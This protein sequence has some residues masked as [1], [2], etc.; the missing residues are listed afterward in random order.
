MLTPLFE[1]KGAREDF[2]EINQNMEGLVVDLT[3]LKPFLSHVSSNEALKERI[4]FGK[5]IYAQGVM[6]VAETEEVASTILV[7]AYF[8]EKEDDAPTCTMAELE[9]F[10]AECYSLKPEDQSTFH[11]MVAE[12]IV[13]EKSSEG[14]NQTEAKSKGSQPKK[15]EQQKEKDK[16]K[17][18]KKQKVVK[19]D[20]EVKKNKK[21]KDKKGK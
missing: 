7:A 14:T 5:E 20:K 10:A 6:A 3:A 21:R 9:K 15:N 1:G 18:D 16:N 12:V 11:E 4:L 8:V 19:K 2:A 13:E 17:K